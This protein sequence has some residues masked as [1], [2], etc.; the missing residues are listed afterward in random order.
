MNGEFASMLLL[1]VQSK[2]RFPLL[3][4][5]HISSSLNFSQSHNTSLTFPLYLSSIEIKWCVYNPAT[6]LHLFTWKT[7]YRVIFL[8]ILN[9]N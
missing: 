4:E 7:R 1:L 5:V 6:Q 8:A 2:T 9:I 3:S